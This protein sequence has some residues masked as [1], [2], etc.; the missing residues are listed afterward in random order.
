RESHEE[1]TTRTA[2]LGGG[3]SR[4]GPAQGPGTVI[5]GAACCCTGTDR[6][7]TGAASPGAGTGTGSG[8]TSGTSIG[9]CTATGTGTGGTGIRSRGT[10]PSSDG[11][12]GPLYGGESGGPVLSGCS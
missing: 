11:G 8:T 4:E 3:D 6:C 2:R 1:S 5:T 9:T 7:L 12:T 10:S